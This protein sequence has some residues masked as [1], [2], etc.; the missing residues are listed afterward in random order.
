MNP[1]TYQVNGDTAIREPISVAET[2]FVIVTFS[3]NFHPFERN[4]ICRKK[5]F[6]CV[7]T[8]MLQN[9]K[10]LCSKEKF[11][12]LEYSCYMRNDVI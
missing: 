4:L 12:D 9:T 3:Y 5:C 6:L 1:T 2:K 8:G 7:R 10:Q 11:T